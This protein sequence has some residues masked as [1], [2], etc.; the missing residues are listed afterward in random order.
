MKRHWM[1]GQRKLAKRKKDMKLEIQRNVFAQY[2]EENQNAVEYKKI[3]TQDIVGLLGSLDLDTIRN[4]LQEHSIEMCGQ[5][6]NDLTK[7][8]NEEENNN[9]EQNMISSTEDDN[10][11]NEER[12]KSE[13]VDKEVI[14][15]P[16]DF[17]L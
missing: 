9:D 17:I 10:E 7:K 5:L 6:K 4:D 13:G 15:E 16:D 3:I 14:L 12:D 11:S 8:K 1:G 2:E